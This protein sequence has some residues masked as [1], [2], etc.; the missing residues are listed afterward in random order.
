MP[1]VDQH[2]IMSIA[3]LWTEL[4]ENCK[5]TDFYQDTK[6][7]H[8]TQINWYVIVLV[9]GDPCGREKPKQDKN[10]LYSRIDLNMQKHK[11]TY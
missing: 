1:D 10:N 2:H 9:A 4:N 7:H 8:I 6:K 5:M 3:D 11:Q